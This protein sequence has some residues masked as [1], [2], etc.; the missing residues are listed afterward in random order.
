MNKHN[1]IPI[2]ALFK[3]INIISSTDKKFKKQYLANPKSIIEAILSRKLPEHLVISA[4]ED[5]K[6]DV[7]SRAEITDME[8]V[9]DELEKIAGGVEQISV[10]VEQ[11]TKLYEQGLTQA[12]QDLIKS[13]LGALT[14]EGNPVNVTL[15]FSN[16]QQ[17]ILPGKL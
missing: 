16:G 12:K 10:S 6:G 3:E 9:Q 14:A 17:L 15:S 8:L 4:S 1:D 11:L 2:E 7:I 5:S 13:G